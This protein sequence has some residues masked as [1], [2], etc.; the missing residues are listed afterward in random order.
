MKKHGGLE[1]LKIGYKF[2]IFSLPYFWKDIKGVKKVSYFNTDWNLLTILTFR[3]SIIL[4]NKQR[5][6]AMFSF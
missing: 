6:P 2:W 4:A 3:K 5:P 1:Y